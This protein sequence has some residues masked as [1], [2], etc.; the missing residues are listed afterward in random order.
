MN[1]DGTLT[2]D[3]VIDSFGEDLGG[4]LDLLA[5]ILAHGS[6]EQLFR[7]ERQTPVRPLLNA[8]S[9]VIT[10]MPDTPMYRP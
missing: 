6:A 8:D 10:H 2:P 5:P 4:R 9:G 3:K 7:L 1:L